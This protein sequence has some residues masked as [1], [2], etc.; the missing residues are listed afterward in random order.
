VLPPLPPTG[1]NFLW[2]QSTIAP[3]LETVLP[4]PMTGYWKYSRI[5]RQ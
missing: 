4:T 1:K 3:P 2:K 5:R